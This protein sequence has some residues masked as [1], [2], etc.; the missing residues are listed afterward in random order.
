MRGR[1]RQWA[2]RLTGLSTP[3]VGASWN[4]PPS[5]RDVAAKLLAR[6]EDR[7]VLFN[8]SEAESAHH[9]VQSMIEVRRLLSESS[10]E[11]FGSGILAEHVRAMGAAARRFLDRVGHWRDDDYSGA[12][13]L[14]HYRAWEFLEALGQMRGVFGVH[15]AMIAARYGLEVTGD[16]AGILPV[17]TS[18]DEFGLK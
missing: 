17:E 11:L 8:P 16:L 10:A 6:L 18:P 12:S 7:R 3:L 14:G 9:C 13:S 2:G 1:M 15:I 4:A 5:E